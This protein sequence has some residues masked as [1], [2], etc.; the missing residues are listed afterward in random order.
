M[1][2]LGEAVNITNNN[3]T[4]NDNIIQGGFSIFVKIGFAILTI[5]ILLAILLR[6]KRGFVFVKDSH[7]NNEEQSINQLELTNPY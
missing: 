4:E 2:K 3:I 5:A 6:S 7:D 1:Q